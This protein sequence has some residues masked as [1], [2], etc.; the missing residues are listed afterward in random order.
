MKRIVKVINKSRNELPKYQTAGA[1]GMDVRA[2]LANI[3]ED[4]GRLIGH[5]CAYDEVG[6]YVMIWPHG[7][8][9]IPTELYFEVPEG[10]EIQVRPRSGLALKAGITVL[11][12]PGTIDSDYRGGLGVILINHSEEP[13][14][15]Q[16]GDRIAQIVLNKVEEMKLESVEELSETDRGEGGFNSTG[17]K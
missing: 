6:N 3:A 13:F 5:K 17:V 12:T 11:N 14:C 8:A 16:Q 2:E 1:A 4:P 10:Y 7:R 15:V 9:L